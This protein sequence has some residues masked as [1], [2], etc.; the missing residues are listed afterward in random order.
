MSWTTTWNLYFSSLGLK[1][2]NVA[3]KAWRTSLM[4]GMPMTV[5]H[6]GGEDDYRSVL[7]AMLRER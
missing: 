6:E 1:G 3:D 7:N 5:R 4:P 2:S